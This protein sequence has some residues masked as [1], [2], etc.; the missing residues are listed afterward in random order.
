MIKKKEYNK[1]K[2]KY[3]LNQLNTYYTHAFYESP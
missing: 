3:K 1:K 2:V